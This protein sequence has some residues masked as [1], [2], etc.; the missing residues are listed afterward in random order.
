VLDTVAALESGDLASVGAALSASHRSLRDD[1]EVSS[2]ALDALV[3]IADAVP[4]VV[5]ARLTGAGFG[6]CTINIVHDDAVGPLREAVLAT[7]PGL[8]G[9]TPRVFEVRAAAGARR[10]A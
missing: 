5:G 2:P 10:I 8:T 9:L 1:F 3:E 4:G 7:Y 6:G